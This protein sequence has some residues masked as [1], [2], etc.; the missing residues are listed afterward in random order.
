[1]EQKDLTV[2]ELRVNMTRR[3]NM[4]SPG[5]DRLTNFW[6]KQFKSLHEP[7]TEAYSEII[8]HPK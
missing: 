6:I 4:K 3:A 8:K 1:M 5:P 2:K 7:M